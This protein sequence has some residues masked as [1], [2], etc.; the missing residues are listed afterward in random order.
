M[1][2]VAGSV[3]SCAFSA[4]LREACVSFSAV[5]VSVKGSNADRPKHTRVK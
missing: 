4:D 3:V 1:V 2:F 5:T